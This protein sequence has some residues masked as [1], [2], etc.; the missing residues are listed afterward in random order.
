[1]LGRLASVPTSGNPYLGRLAGSLP[2]EDLAAARAWLH[3]VEPAVPISLR[4]ERDRLWAALDATSDLAE[5]PHGLVHPDAHLGNVI[6]DKDQ[7]E[8][9]VDWDGAGQGP[10]ISSLGWAL[11]GAGLH[12][13][14]R[15]E[16][17]F[18]GWAAYR[19][20]A[21]HEIARL[22][23]AIHFRPLTLAVRSF[24]A[25]LKEST[26]PAHPWAERYRE[27]EAFAGLALAELARE[28]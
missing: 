8:V 2:A 21:D 1:V 17:L 5:L 22:P 4:A 23:D 18:Q 14:G 20:L 11:Y 13:P 25:R 10:R 9:L 19:H 24:V 16:A 7:V 27:A 26:D 15:L 12:G 28:R 3:D 6:V